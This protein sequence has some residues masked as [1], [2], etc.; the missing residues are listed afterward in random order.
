MKIKTAFQ[1]L[2]DMIVSARAYAETVPQA[3]RI[4]DWSPGQPQWT[5]LHAV[6]IELSRIWHVLKRM[7]HSLFVVLATGDDLSLRSLDYGTERLSASKA[8]TTLTVTCSGAGT[9]T[10]GLRAASGTGVVFVTQE[11]VIVGGALS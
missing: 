6:A 7:Y 5:L 3:R 8:S 11:E 1:L 2:S 4:T 9:L 10:S